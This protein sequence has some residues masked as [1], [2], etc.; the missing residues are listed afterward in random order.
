MYSNKN[1]LL[2]VTT[3]IYDYSN[4]NNIQYPTSINTLYNAYL[5]KAKLA[6]S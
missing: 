6:P 5:I 2:P 1:Y 4:S 3:F